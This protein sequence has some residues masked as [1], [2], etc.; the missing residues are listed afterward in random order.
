MKNKFFPLIVIFFVWVIFSSPYLFFGKSPFPSDY[1][2][3]FFSPW[4]VYPGH[5]GPV[6][7]NAQPDII[8]QIYPWR[9]FVI[10]EYKAGRIPFWNPYSFSGTP[11]LANYQS[12]ALSPL[13]ILFFLPFEFIDV[14]SILVLL[15]PLIAGI[16]MYMLSRK[17]VVSKGGSLLSSF[18]FMF[19]GFLVTWMGYATLGYAILLLPLAYFTILEY[20]STSSYRWLMLLSTTFFFSFFAGHFQMSIYFAFGVFSF[21]F[22]NLIFSKEKKLYADAILFSFFGLLMVMPQVLPSIEFYS[23]S[24]RSNLFQKVEA[25]PWNYLPTLLSPDFY[26]NPVTRND[27]YGHY[28]EWSG[29]SGIVAIVFSFAAVLFKRSKATMFFIGLAIGSLLLAYD[30]PLLSLLV[31]LKVPVIS[32]SAASRIIVLFSFAIAVLA[33]FGFDEVLSLFKKSKKKVLL[34]ISVSSLPL[35]IVV[36]IPFL[37]LLE[38][39]KGHIAQKNII[40]TAL[41]FGVVCIL[42]FLVLFIKNKHTKLLFIVC[43][44]SISA[45]E[46][47]RFAAKWQSFSPKQEAY[48]NVPVASFYEKQNGYDRAIGLSGEED[49]VYYGIPTLGGYDPLYIDIYGQFIQYVGSGEYR[50]PERSVVTFP[51]NGKYTAKAIDFLGVKYVIHK[52]SDG[53]MVWAFPFRRYPPEQFEKIYDDGGYNVFVNKNAYPKAFI[54]SNVIKSTS[55]N[56][57]FKKIF[58]YDLRKTAI[59]SDQIEGLDNNAK[60]TAKIT[61]Y[62]SNKIELEVTT[63]GISLLVLT[64]SFYPG[65]KAYV[66]G[67][68]TKIYKTDYAFRGI[69]VPSGKSHV[70]FSYTP[71]SFLVGTYLFLI[72]IM[73]MVIILVIRKFKN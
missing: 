43:I 54:V 38:G 47:Y 11:H 66:K 10:Q 7:N 39:D 49:S 48:I 73:G 41:I 31:S 32:T 44:L 42:T 53:E 55:R 69:V 25:I 70:V 65:W 28:A 63:S 46:M 52:T 67:K 23:L 2:N 60:G 18:S 36:I 1:Q 13:N 56:N 22:Y 33:G 20:V 14:W 59:V 16:F 24:V 27:W 4:N 64:D 19:C 30:T 50:V 51:L 61:K 6:K 72:G 35:A 12:A 29:F 15:Q 9:Y 8:T 57:E 40:L 62:T 26:G 3:N 17:L 34:W 21:I 5:A 68:P 58:E 37:N 45:F 71:Q